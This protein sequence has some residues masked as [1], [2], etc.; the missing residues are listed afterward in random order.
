MPASMDDVVSLAKR[1]GFIFQNSEIYGGQQG[2]WDYGPLGTSLKRN[3]REAW[4]R[5]MVT[6]HDELN[7]PDGAPSSYEMVGLETAIIMHPRVW[8]S[9]GHYDLF[10]DFMA[11]CKSC[12]SRFRVDQVTVYAAVTEG[13]EVAASEAFLK[14]EEQPDLSK[15]KRKRLDRA[16]GNEGTLTETTLDRYLKQHPD[17]PV[18]GCPNCGGE[19]TE[20]REF[21]LM[22]KDHAGG[23]RR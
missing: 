10:H 15:T 2:F 14:T 13:G 21:N 9:S 20:P 16:A 6:R 22:F 8:K 4:W 11:D 7:T 17:A 3:V 18:P 5:E 19:L 12:K 23:A 1:R